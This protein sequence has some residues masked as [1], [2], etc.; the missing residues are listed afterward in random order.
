MQ[1]LKAI[2][3]DLINF[4]VVTLLSLLIGLE[5]RRHH[6]DDKPESLYGT[7]R[8]YTFI[9]MLGFILYVISPKNLSAFLSGGFAL[10]IVLGI[11]YW[12]R[13]EEQNKYGITS[14]VI[15]L[16][17]YSLAPLIYVK[18]AWLTILAVT[19]VLVLTE[20]KPQFKSLTGRFDNDEFVI[21][22]KFMVIAGIILPLLPNK[23]ISTVLPISP[24]K[25][26]LAVVVISGISY[27]SYLLHKFILPGKG[28]LITGI[29]GGMY[30]S[31][32][33][34]VVLAR[35]SKDPD[36]A[37]FKISGS[38]ILATGM[39]FIRIF[40][41]AL[42]FNYRLASGLLFPFFALCL[43]TVVVSI[44]IWKREKPGKTNDVSTA[45]HKNPL[46]FKTAIL[47]AVLFLI[48]ALLTKY[49]MQ[50]FGTKGLNILSLVVGVTDIDPF[51]L[52]LFTGK[53]QILTHTMANATL[54]AVTS[55]N[56]IKLIYALFL[57][58]KKLR[59]PLIFG[60]SVIIAVSIL[61]I[62]FY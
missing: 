29:L 22:A 54:I 31:T 37:I 15:V 50:N 12:K 60:F 46:E 16:I 21:L 6:F 20:L 10:I 4:V 45:K 51:L 27:L 56:V 58:S 43:L 23:D 36:S 26:W 52:S 33:T 41:L 25:V 8:T 30:S 1:M 11:F 62:T 34:T 32:A 14:I 47:F 40:V 9:G 39:M 35:K 18:P 57:G 49:V 55:N 5:Q 19:I 53:Y 7:D 42:I 2:P 61:I 44:I 48:F 38:I 28:M 24:Y 13:I 59:K 17:T 3:E